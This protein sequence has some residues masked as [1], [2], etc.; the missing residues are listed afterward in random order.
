M[1]VPRSGAALGV[2]K[3]DGAYYHPEDLPRSAIDGSQSAYVGSSQSDQETVP[4]YVEAV[5]RS[6]DS[7]E[8]HPE[9]VLSDIAAV[10]DRGLLTARSGLSVD[11][12]S[13][14]SRGAFNGWRAGRGASASP[15]AGV[16]RAVSLGILRVGRR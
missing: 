15:A 2:V 8:G 7:A 4:F 1:G 14:S 16:R 3:Y 9:D 12:W 10:V 5:Y 6:L 11:R 13:G